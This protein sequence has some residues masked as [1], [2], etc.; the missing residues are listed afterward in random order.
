MI[1][2]E[3]AVILPAR[4]NSS[5][6]PGKPLV[7]VAGKPL[8][9]W[10]YQRAESIRG[11]G[12][13]IVATDNKDI[14]SK[15]ESFGGK[16]VM[17]STRHRTGTDRVAEAAS[18]L[19]FDV[20]VNLQGDEPVVPDGLVEGMVA[21]LRKTPEAG[22]AT[23][24]HKI[25]NPGDFENPNIVKVVMDGAGGALYF[26][27]API[28]YGAWKDLHGAGIEAEAYRHIGIYA[29]RRESLAAFAGMQPSPLEN[30]EGL[31]QMRA[32]EN[33]MR[34]NVLITETPT[35]GVDV[36]EDIIIVEKYLTK[37]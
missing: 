6:F 17:T 14:A 20:I 35:I 3:F 15:V 2:G 33:G 27:R 24:C 1:A 8:I 29:F 9:Q 4:F 31:E 34:I 16:A 10:V 37:T 21:G 11:A 30:A 36:P 19:E 12:I 5:R 23:A 32:L 22:I 7:E 26:S 28:P 18:D 13:V 25:D